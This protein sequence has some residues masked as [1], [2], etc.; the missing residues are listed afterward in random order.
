MVLSYPDLVAGKR[1][2]GARVAIIGAGGIGFDVAEF[3]LHRHCVGD[4]ELTS[5]QCEW[6]VETNPS[7]SGGLRAP[8]AQPS[9]RVV[10]LLQRTP[11][12]L[13]RTLGLT[14]GWALKIRLQRLGLRMISGCSYDR[15]DDAGLHLRVNAEPRL[16]EVDNV[17]VCA[18]QE[19]NAAL[20]GE[21]AA[22]GVRTSLIGGARK[23]GELDALAAIHE[24]AELAWSF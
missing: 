6:G 10:Y 4:N 18:G 9:G 22:L 21:L 11:G 2:A 24:G 14:T 16:L 23:A 15:I 1:K 12:K 8:H 5:Y 19:P 3:L 17:V 13:G 7:S 20:H